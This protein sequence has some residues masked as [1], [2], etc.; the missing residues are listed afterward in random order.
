MATL[1]WA[2]LPL[3]NTHGGGEGEANSS[4]DV[5]ATTEGDMLGQCGF[6]TLNHAY[7]LTT[8]AITHSL[9]PSN[10]PYLVAP[11]MLS[12]CWPT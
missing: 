12:H 8:S 5:V 7:I 2:L 1:N 9:L 10:P 11:C 3:Q 6:H 4:E